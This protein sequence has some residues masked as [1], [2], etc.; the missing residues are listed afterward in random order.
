MTYAIMPTGIN[1]IVC[2]YG[3]T[4]KTPEV[5]APGFSIPF[6]CGGLNHRLVTDYSSP[7]SHLQMRWQTT[8][9]MTA[10]IN[11]IAIS[12]GAVAESHRN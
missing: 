3:T 2:P 4:T 10:M 11:D 8:P 6:L 9:A 1:D 12:I 7:S 5:V